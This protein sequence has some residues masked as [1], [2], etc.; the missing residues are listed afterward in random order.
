MV[1][2][3]SGVVNRRQSRLSLAVIVVVVPVAV[4]AA[5]PLGEDRPELNR[6]VEPINLPA[7]AKAAIALAAGALLLTAGGALTLPAGRTATRREDVK[8]AV[9]LVVAGLY[10]AVTYN[11]MTQPVSGANIGAGIMFMLGC[12]LIPALLLL[13]AW[14]V[15][16]VRRRGPVR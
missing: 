9:P 4:W 8:V 12:L 1:V 15:W 5:L 6:N 14:R 11:G 3:Q 2:E 7:E 16:Q 13:S 10:A